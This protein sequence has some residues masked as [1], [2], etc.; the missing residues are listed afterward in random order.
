MKSKS[1]NR[2]LFLALAVTLQ[3]ASA[4]DK[5]WNPSPLT[6]NWNSVTS[7]TA[8]WATTS[9]GTPNQVWANGNDA[10][11]DQTGSYT[12]ST[13]E[14][15]TAGTINVSAGNVTFAGSSGVKAATVTIGNGA[16]VGGAVDRFI[17]TGTTA[18][19][20]NGTLNPAA[21]S[22]GSKFVSLTGSG[23]ISGVSTLRYAGTSDFSGNIGGTGAVILE[24]G[25]IVGIGDS[26][27]FSG[28]N[29]YS[30]D[31]LLRSTVGT[32]Q[33]SS[34]GALSPN[35]F[36]RFGGGT[37]VVELAN[38][39]FT[40]ALGGTAGTIRFNNSSDGAGSSGF[41]AI[42][43]D[44]T[45]AL[46]GGL[47]WSNYTAGTTTL[48][49]SPAQFILGNANSTNK[50][51]LVSDLDLGAAVRTISSTNGAAL[52]EGEISGIISNGSLTK[53]GTGTI[54]LSADNTFA[55]NV[56]FGSGSSGFLRL[57]HSNA[58]GPDATAKLVDTTASTS[59]ATGGIELSGGLTI[60]NKNLNAGGRTAGPTYATLRNV[61]G[62]NSWNGNITF[63]NT[64]GSNLNI[65]VASGKL[66]LGGTLSAVTITGNRNFYF[67]GDGDT[68][69]SG[70]LQNGSANVGIDK[71]GAGTMT[72]TNTNTAT[73]N[74]AVTTGTLSLG[75]GTT[76][77]DGT[78]AAATITTNA[79]L[80]F[81]RFANASNASAISGTGNV[82]KLGVGTQTL[83]GSN[84]WAGTT[85][86][87]Q[88]TLEAKRTT[89]V[90]LGT[91]DV[92]VSSGA[93]LQ[94]TD[95][96][97][98][99]QLDYT[100][101]LI[102]SGTG[103]GGNGA[104]MFYNSAGFSMTGTVN[105][106]ANTLINNN[107]SNQTAAISFTNTISGTGGLT[108]QGSSTGT[109]GAYFILSAAN[110]YG[111][112]NQTTT[113]ANTSIRLTRLEL[114]T[115]TNV[116][117]SSTTLT[118]AGTGPTD[119][120]LDG[121]SQ[122][123]AGL[124]ETGA[125]THR[126]VGNSATNATFIV[127]NASANSFAGSIGGAATNENNIDLDKTG[128]GTLTLTGATTYSGNTTVENGVLSIA[129]N[130]FSDTSTVTIGKV[131]A[132]PAILN[133]PTSG[134]D[135]VASL[136]IDGVVQAAGVT[137][138]SSNSGGAITGSGKILV[139]AAPAAGYATW[140]SSFTSP[141]LSDTAATA[142]PDFD[143]IP[144]SVEYVTGGDPR[145]SS[146][147]NLPT[148][149]ISGGNLIFTFNRVDSSE[150]PDVSLVVETSSN[151]ADWASQ[152]SYSIGADTASSTLGVDIAENGAAADTITV[153]IPAT[154]KGF[155]RL[156]V[157]TTP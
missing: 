156:R 1:S 138:D 13:T 53:T 131:A 55:G 96:A 93:T 130:S 118:F 20:L 42:G 139:S 80:I 137:Y 143:G 4:T 24:N 6:G 89:Q 144:N 40:R 99:G 151:L 128:A 65:D 111:T 123:V 147:T 116:L 92:T 30:G 146:Q 68:L 82:T 16:T 3:S 133:L 70:V 119:L 108:L 32:L 117:P 148:S 157:I 18:L 74:I 91:G 102:L 35:T 31:T 43:A 149:M 34:S 51:T 113:L 76:G 121:I 79:E 29:T 120:L 86:V 59:S 19:Q 105:L 41:A 50:V 127:N 66:T 145:V 25:G 38:G 44:R 142:D 47:I 154:T 140:A 71:G 134:T 23:T 62:D 36:L 85:L 60:N 7:P 73:G 9:G 48:T 64:G 72:L 39:N 8:N 2:L 84:S 100:S 153:T 83:T 17:G 45:V 69:I 122:T 155:V 95:H 63:A 152:P 21:G 129:S 57:T 14:A 77:N 28:T 104:L 124:A 115:V 94:I 107:S 58:L 27:K 10:F 22:G 12:V 5:F 26:I 112:G 78:T 46:T 103:D 52:V 97:G 132:S 106:A 136:V 67:R 33:L 11:F 90:G 81:N 114:S 150:T 109:A 56:A 87:S 125:A 110:T 49:F 61:A 141:P 98:S 135:T 126:I 15:L 75:D 101:N 37:N 54:I 88:G